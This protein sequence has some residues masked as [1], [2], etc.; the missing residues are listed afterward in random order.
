MPYRLLADTVVVL[1][2]A[3]T[4]FVVVGGFLAHRWHA[5][6]WIHIPSAIWGALIEFAGWTCPLTPLENWF[7]LKGGA[8]GYS[9]GFIEQYILPLLYP[10]NLTRN[11]QLVLGT[12]VIFVNLG[13]YTSLFIRCRKD[14]KGSG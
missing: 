5:V 12:L 2:L 3:F 8:T 4:I 7:R 1:H 11:I 9:S 14:K 13:A 6:I 10:V